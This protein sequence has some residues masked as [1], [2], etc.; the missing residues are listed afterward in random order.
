MT[1]YHVS[2]AFAAPLVLFLS[3]ENI[4]A[5]KDQTVKESVEYNA[6][7]YTVRQPNEVEVML[8]DAL[9]CASGLKTLSC[10]AKHIWDDGECL[11]LAS[12]EPHKLVRRI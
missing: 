10:A 9:R 2:E 11:L 4:Q 8:E 12:V 6:T 1:S 5:L 3:A 7:E